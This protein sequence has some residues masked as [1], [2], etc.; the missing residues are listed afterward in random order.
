MKIFYDTEFLEN[1]RTIELISIGM[2]REDEKKLYLINRNFDPNKF[3]MH[4][5]LNEN[6]AR[7]L[8]IARTADGYWFWNGRKDVVVPRSELAEKVKQFVLEVDNPE[9]W[10]YYSAYDHVA[11]VQL[12][13]TMMQLPSGFP[14]FT[15][16][17]KSLSLWLDRT[18]PEQEKNQHDALSDALWCRTAYNVIDRNV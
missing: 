6:V 7:H 13:G 11:L 5:W 1:G 10:A 15:H 12:F 14:M 9:L 4:V 18:L 17:L 16:D 3:K 2:V 8:P